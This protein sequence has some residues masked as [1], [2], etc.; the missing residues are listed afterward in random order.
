MPA[1]QDATFNRLSEQVNVNIS[2]KES[3]KNKDT[4]KK[5]LEN[6]QIY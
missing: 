5:T 4:A 1:V 2:H 6:A 3:H